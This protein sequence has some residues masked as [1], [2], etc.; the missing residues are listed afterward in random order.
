VPHRT[1]AILLE[2][3]LARRL[4]QAH[5]DWVDDVERAWWT[6]SGQPTLEPRA[7]EHR[8]ASE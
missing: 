1:E 8:D 2:L 5:R 4:I 6:G 3:S 7:H